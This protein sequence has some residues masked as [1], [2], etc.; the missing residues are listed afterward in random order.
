M[1]HLVL[2][3]GYHK[4]EYEIVR[5]EWRKRNVDFHFVNSKEEAVRQLRQV[6]Y[7]CV[8]VCT[9]RIDN[10]DLDAIRGIQPIP[11]L[12]LSPECD[13]EKRA[14]VIQRG[15]AKFILNAN[16][17]KEAQLNG[18]DAVQ[19]Y[20]D[21]PDKGENALTAVTTEDIYFCFEYRSV[22]V[23]GHR[24][25]LTAKEF[26]ILAL[27]ITHPKRVYTFT[28]I[29]DLVWGEDSDF[30]S[31]KTLSNYMSSIRKKLKVQ[32]DM[33]NYIV[34]VHGIGYKFDPDKTH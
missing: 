26:D 34:S 3:I 20:L 18:K 27:L 22:E 14:E 33:P 10:M 17:W 15:V 13:I 4:D 21:L 7:I 31:Q 23:R 5:H 29:M 1:A 9:N 24:V 11:V 16:Q 30:Y 8:T 25:I 32:P 2:G 19:Y 12:V 6:P 28:M